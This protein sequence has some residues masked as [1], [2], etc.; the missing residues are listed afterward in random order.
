MITIRETVDGDLPAL[1]ALRATWA[2]EQAPAADGTT[3]DPE[4]FLAALK[5]WLEANPRTFFLAEDD[6]VPVGMLNLMVFE[7]MPK[8]GKDISRWVYMGNVFVLPDRRNAGIGAQLVEAALAYS[9]EINAVRMLLS[10]SSE[11]RSFYARLG[12]VPAEEL[13]VLTF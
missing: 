12:F 5:R 1:A 11:S 4:A 7:R 2:A 13:N 3:V 10:P 9:R 8:P 6:G